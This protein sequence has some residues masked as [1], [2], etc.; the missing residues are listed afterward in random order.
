[1][2][3][4]PYDNETRFWLSVKS[5]PDCWEWT[6]YKIWNG[7]GQMRF[8]KQSKYVHRYSWEL[9]FGEITD[10]LFVLHRCDNR[11]CVRPSH[12]FLGTND[13]NMKDMVAKER[14]S[15]GETSGKATRTE[16]DIR[17]IRRVAE[18]LPYKEVASLFNASPG[19]VSLIVNR[20]SWSHVN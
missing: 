20:K 8:N 5:S 13:D 7:Y 19:N 4:L 15:R 10:G 18:F 3:R 12:L 2:T 14:Q 1:M 17:L 16:D 11:A 9:H 6:G